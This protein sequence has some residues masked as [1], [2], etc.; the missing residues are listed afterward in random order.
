M[1]APPS[2]VVVMNFS[3]DNSDIQ[4][5]DDFP[6]L[7]NSAVAWLTR[8]EASP[9]SAWKTNE[10]IAWGDD[11]EAAQLTSPYGV[12]HDRGAVLADAGLWRS[13][14]DTL[15]PVNL[16]EVVES[17]LRSEV[18]DLN[19]KWPHVAWLPDFGPLWMPLVALA[20]VWLA[21]Q[22]AFYHR[23]VID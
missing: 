10:A 8:S 13:G 9:R 6:R 3:P 22:W 12:A 23:G 7:L 2:P 19:R 20:L 11:N 16:T 15:L 18:A 5:H 1:A 14:D 4:W 17:D 21:A